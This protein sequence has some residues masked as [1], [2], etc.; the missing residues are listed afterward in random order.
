MGDLYDGAEKPSVV[1]QNFLDWLTETKRRQEE[2]WKQVEEE[3]RRVQD[4][5]HEFEFEGSRSRRSPIGTRLH[6]S[7][8]KRRQAKDR[9]SLYKPVKDFVDDATNRGYI[10]RLKKLQGDLK[11]QE[12]FLESERVYKPRAE[13]RREELK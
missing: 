2:Y 13:E 11:A 7:R 12:A 10:K 4:F 5:L 9:A 3:D 1:I 8:V 6:M